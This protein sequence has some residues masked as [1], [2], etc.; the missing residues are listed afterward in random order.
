MLNVQVRRPTNRVRRKRFASASDSLQK[1][2]FYPLLFSF[3]LL[4]PPFF[5]LIFGNSV[6]YR[7]CLAELPNLFSGESFFR[8]ARN[9]A[10]ADGGGTRILTAPG[11]GV[12]FYRYP[13]R[14]NHTVQVLPEPAENRESGE[15]PVRYRRCKRRGFA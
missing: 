4:Y 2:W 14:C 3:S 8:F 7:S 5:S 9:R 1:Q 13:F 15:N 10:L 6:R 11:A 12:I